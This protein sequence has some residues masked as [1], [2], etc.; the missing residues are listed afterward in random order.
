MYRCW[1]ELKNLRE[2]QG[3]V[4][5]QLK[6]VIRR[7]V[8]TCVFNQRFSSPIPSMQCCAA[9]RATYR[10]FALTWLSSKQIYWNKRK[11]LHKKRV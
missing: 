8:T 4:N 10:A 1:R 2:A 7:S 3:Y 5:T 6:L 9:V 11:I